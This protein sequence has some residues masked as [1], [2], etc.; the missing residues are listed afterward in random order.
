MRR[1]IRT[2]SRII[3]EIGSVLEAGQCHL[4]CVMAGSNRCECPCD[5]AYHGIGILV[6]GIEKRD[7][8]KE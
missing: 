6:I 2:P 1:Q 3:Q 8:V 7:G 4:S 5:G